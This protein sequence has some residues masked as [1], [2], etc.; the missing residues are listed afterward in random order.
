MGLVELSGKTKKITPLKSPLTNTDCVLYKYLVEEYRSSGK[1][2]RW[3]TIASG[4]SLSCSFWLDDGTGKIMVFPYGAELF[5][6]ID[7]EFNTRGW[8][9]LPPNLVGFMDSNAISYKSWLGARRLRFKEWYVCEDETI[10]VLGTAKASEISTIGHKE[11]LMQRLA[12]LKRNQEK[13]K[14][15]DIDKDGKVSLEEW[16]LAVA[17]V[18]E[19]VLKEALKA[20]PPENSD[21]V[22]ITKGDVEKI[23]IISDYSQKDLTKKLSVQSLL[24]IYGG[25]ALSLFLLGYILLRLGIF[26]F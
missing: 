14:E 3:V 2:G 20:A 22:I 12:E 8:G 5:W 10:Y 21:D 24:G 7:Y 15:V 16:D 25:A 18:E 6:P 4:D 17:K 26:R 9:S 13:M 1:S 11:Q 23:F 19:Q